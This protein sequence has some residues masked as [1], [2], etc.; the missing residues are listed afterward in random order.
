[1]IIPD[2]TMLA[3]ITGVLWVFRRVSASCETCQPVLGV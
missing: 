1:M 2:V 3:R